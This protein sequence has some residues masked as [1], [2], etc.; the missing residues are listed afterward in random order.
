M[1]MQRSLQLNFYALCNFVYIRLNFIL[2][3]SGASTSTGRSRVLRR[4]LQSYF[5]SSQK[6]T[7][8]SL[9]QPQAW[10]DILKLSR[11]TY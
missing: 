11:R 2:K 4:M 3:F 9:L 1:K 6:E 10:T 8:E 7:P 5:L